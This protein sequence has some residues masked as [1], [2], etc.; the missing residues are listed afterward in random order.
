[1]SILICA[2]DASARARAMRLSHFSRFEAMHVLTGSPPLNYSA[3]GEDIQ[4]Y[5][6]RQGCETYL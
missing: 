3:R 6:P 4:K 2:G 5:G 1:M